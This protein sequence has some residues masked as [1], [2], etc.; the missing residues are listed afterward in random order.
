[1]LDHSPDAFARLDDQGVVLE[2]NR[3]GQVFFEGEPHL[4][5]AAQFVAQAQSSGLSQQRLEVQRQGKRWEIWLSLAGSDC[6]LQG[7]VL[8]ETVSQAVYRSAAEGCPLS[9]IRYDREGRIVY[10]NEKLQH[11]LGLKDRSEVLGLHPNEIWPD[12]RF[13]DITR[14]LERALCKGE[15]TKIDFQEPLDGRLFRYHSVLMV[16]EYEESGEISGAIAFGQECTALRQAEQLA[17]ERDWSLQVLVDNLPVCLARF[18]EQLVCL[19]VSPAVTTLFERP[20]SHFE[21]HPLNQLS[22]GGPELAEEVANVFRYGEQRQTLTWWET[23]LGERT[24]E[25][26]MVPERR[27]PHRVETV[28]CIARDVTDEQKAQRE[29]RLLS[30]A[31]NQSNDASYLIN[32]E[33]GLEYVNEL[34]CRTLGYT[35]EELTQ[36]KV[37]DIDPVVTLDQVLQ[38]ISNETTARFETFHCTR[39]GHVF[40]VEITSSLVSW[41]S[42]TYSWAIARDISGRKQMEDEVR[43]VLS[44]ARAM[45]SRGQLQ[46]SENWQTASLEELA[47]QLRWQLVFDD[48]A[49]AQSILPLSL[50]P[51]EPYAQAWLLAQLPEDHQRLARKVAAALQSGGSSYRDEFRARDDKGRI[52]WFSHT[53]NL[54]WLEQ[55][56]WRVTAITGDITERKLLEEKFLQSQKLEAVGQLAGGVAHDFNNILTAMLLQLE[57]LREE[58]DFSGEVQ[59]GLRELRHNTERATKLVQQLLLFSRKHMLQLGSCDLNLVLDNLYGL[60]RRS[61]PEDIEIQ[62]RPYPKPLLVEADV[63]LLEQVV[64]NLAVNARDAMPEGGLLRIET[65]LEAGMVVLRVVDSGT[66]IDAETLPRIFEPFFTTKEVGKGSGLGLASAFGIIHQHG[67]EIMAASQPGQGTTFE[68][69]LPLCLSASA[70]KQSLPVPSGGAG[71]GE[72]I[73][74]VEDEPL[75]RATISKILQRSG[76]RVLSAQDGVEAERLFLQEGPSI[77]LI[78]TDLVLPGGVSGRQFAHRVRRDAPEQR[79][80]FMSGYSSE[81]ADLEGITLLTK[82]IE[83]GTLLSSIRNVLSS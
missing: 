4:A 55:G 23:P 46:V 81:K 50:R 33:A 53:A 70:P 69:R 49:H 35:F 11:F 66:G 10:L 16:P 57:L 1:M 13:R 61:L 12:G 20:Y 63:S 83:L 29:L 9:F 26:V 19:Y 47:S 30:H 6:W 28:L 32:S 51:G 15:R 14:A 41:G 67:G 82:P 31:V 5:E 42:E 76:Y 68:I 73:L 22:C 64:V 78:L 60:L 43:R 21:G 48:E 37:P 36:M 62:F 25:V 44:H 2:C 38:M 24:F 3:A 45:V 18:D 7:R 58:S 27:E 65:S 77:D 40:P 17:Q 52:H 54:E 79:I 8:P 34:A 80:L 74:L 75:V 56:C 59:D 72:C 39:D 71:S